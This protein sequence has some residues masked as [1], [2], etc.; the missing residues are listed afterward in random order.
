MHLKNFSRIIP[1]HAVP[2]SYQDIQKL[3]TKWFFRCSLIN[4]F[5]ILNCG[6]AQKILLGTREKV[7]IERIY[8][9]FA[10]VT[11]FKCENIILI[12]QNRVSFLRHRVKGFQA[13]IHMLFFIETSF[14]GIET[15][16]V[17]S[18]FDILPCRTCK[19]FYSRAE[20]SQFNFI[21]AS[22]PPHFYSVF[23]SLHTATASNSHFFLS[24]FRNFD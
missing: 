24:S 1:Q 15:M 8:I 14:E 13:K 3:L 9:F 6:F 20:L 7:A 4:I 16:C 19:D 21:D 23:S 2:I 5:E 18:L 11:N 12:T 22:F 10:F 17:V